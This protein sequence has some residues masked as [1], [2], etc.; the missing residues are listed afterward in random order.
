MG[1]DNECDPTNASVDILPK[2][3]TQPTHRP[4]VGRRVDGIAFVTVGG[5]RVNMYGPPIVKKFRT[6]LICISVALCFEC[7]LLSREICMCQ[8]QQSI[9]GFRSYK[10]I[11]IIITLLFFLEYYFMLFT[12]KRKITEPSPLSPKKKTMT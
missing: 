11:L 1:Y 7:Q 4:T 3:N 6:S 9:L 10:G 5:H 8:Q 2:N 12:R